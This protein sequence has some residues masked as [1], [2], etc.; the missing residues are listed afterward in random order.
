MRLDVDAT[1]IV[2]ALLTI[3]RIGAATLFAPV[4]GVSQVPTSVRVLWIVGLGAVIFSGIHAVQAPL[5]DPITLVLAG[6]SEILIGACFSFGLLTAYAATQFAGRA[7]DIQI[8]F[9]VAAVLNPAT[10]SMGALVGSVFGM[11]TM[12]MFLAMNGHHVL[13]RALV[14]S[15]ENYPP[16]TFGFAPDLGA[17][18]GQSSAIFSFGL[19]L[20]GPVMLALLLA[21][22]ALAVMARSLPQL[23]VFVLSFAIKVVLGTVGLA[24]SIRLSE[25]IVE[26]MFGSTFRFWSDMAGAY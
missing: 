23:N 21:D 6:A 18:L 4:L 22:I 19:A 11:T 3:T 8:G 14:S 15:L 12:V 26:S 7:L 24:L 20:A 10:R 25:T 2:G 13:L 9:G 5:G 17:L 16:G 1:W